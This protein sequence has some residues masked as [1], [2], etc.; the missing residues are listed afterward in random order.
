MKCRMF[1]QSLLCHRDLVL[2]EAPLP[3]RVCLLRAASNAK[4]LSKNPD[5]REGVA[6]E[7]RGLQET[8]HE[9]LGGGRQ[10]RFGQLPERTI[11]QTFSARPLIGRLRQDGFPVPDGFVITADDDVR[12]EDVAAAYLADPLQ[13]NEKDVH[14]NLL[15]LLMILLLIAAED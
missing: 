6:E 10:R 3:D 1:R 9:F 7:F 4:P 13:L 14:Q 11:C 15:L 2:P 12:A 5:L 8:T